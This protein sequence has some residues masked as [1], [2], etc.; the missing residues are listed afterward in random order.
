M[1]VTK[2][3]PPP[4]IIDDKIT[5][6][7]CKFVFFIEKSLLI[8][9]GQKFRQFRKEQKI[10]LC[11]AA[12]DI[13]SKSRLAR[14]EKGEGSMPFS[15]VIKLLKRIHIQPEELIKEGINLS[16]R[17]A[18]LPISVAYAKNDIPFL[19]KKAYEYVK[20]YHQHFNYDNL[21]KAA[22]TCHLYKDLSNNDIFSE[23]DRKKLTNVLFKVQD[24]HY[25]DVF[26]F[27]NT[28]LLLKDHD[29][30]RL[31]M[32]LFT[33]LK[34]QDSVAKDVF[35]SSVNTILNAIFALLKKKDPAEAEKLIKKF[36]ELQ[37][38]DFYPLEKIRYKF[39]EGLLRYIKFQDDTEIKNVFI[40]LDYLNM[41]TFQKDLTVA[42]NQIKRIY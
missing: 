1:E 25:Q 21:I 2:I 36:S 23:Q 30:Y 28:Q 17:K 11:V 33:Y 13:T 42:F 7:L 10:T 24:W 22:V 16:L 26:S 20:E 39:M 14:W 29:I 19:K 5:V 37:L 41:N 3:N 9:Y 35:V 6:N 38:S 18:L 27:G 12:K 4:H 40:I 32:S 34:Y 31:T 8:V 15:L